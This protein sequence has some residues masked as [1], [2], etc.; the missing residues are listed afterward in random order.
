MESQS[1][2]NRGLTCWSRDIDVAGRS[3]YER[4][5]LSTITIDGRDFYSEEGIARDGVFGHGWKGRTHDFRGLGWL[6]WFG[7]IA[8]IVLEV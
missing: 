6:C 7:K 8:L 3:R 4:Y 1:A 2:K 5:G